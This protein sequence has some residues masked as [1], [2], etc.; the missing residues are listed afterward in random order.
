LKKHDAY[1]QVSGVKFTYNP[2]RVW[3]DRITSVM[4]EDEQGIF[5]PLD[6]NK[7]YRGC[8]NMYTAAMID[9]VSFASHGLIKVEP[10]DHLG[11]PLTDPHKAI[12]YMNNSEE[13]KEWLALTLYL[14]SFEK[15]AFQIPQIP[16]KYSNAEG[17]YL[18]QPSLNPADLIYGGNIITYA[19]F[20]SAFLFIFICALTAFIVAKK[21]CKKTR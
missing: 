21:M 7:L 13:L 14:R 10:K 17:R 19:A 20:F 12:V 16:D 8:V 18:A 3:F 2:R 5:Q 4:V 15:N 6:K 11:N 1:L 9:Y